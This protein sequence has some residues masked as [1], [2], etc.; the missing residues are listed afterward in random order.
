[1]GAELERPGR[2]D[3]VELHRFAAQE[4]RRP[5][6]GRRREHLPACTHTASTSGVA[7]ATV[8]RG[9]A[10]SVTYRGAQQRAR[11]VNTRVTTS[12]QAGVVDA[13]KDVLKRLSR[14]ILRKKIISVCVLK[15]QPKHPAAVHTGGIQQTPSSGVHPKLYC[16]KNYNF[17]AVTYL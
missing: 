3:A 12:A 17:C 9:E 14:I 15:V 10:L 4:Q 6:L 13:A 2:C 8:T 5:A 16:L 11:D 1:M 7:D